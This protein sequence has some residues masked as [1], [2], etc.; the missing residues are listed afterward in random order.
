VNA[1]ARPVTDEQRE[2]AREYV[3][4]HVL[5]LRGAYGFVSLRRYDTPQP[6]YGIHEI[7]GLSIATGIRAHR[8]ASFNSR[9]VG[10]VSP[11]ICDEFLARMRYENPL[12]ST[13][14]WRHMSPTLRTLI[15]NGSIF[16]MEWKNEETLDS[17][18]LDNRVRFTAQTA[19]L[20]FLTA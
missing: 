5:Q 9:V 20:R 12:V 17:G 16:P 4:G 15:F 1:A 6:A 10:L 8:G 2:A 7:T 11:L 13:M 14:T 18:Y 19:I 3:E